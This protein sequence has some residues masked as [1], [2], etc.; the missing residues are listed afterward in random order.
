MCS[1]NQRDSFTFVLSEVESHSIL[2]SF[3]FLLVPK[4]VLK[5]TR[6]LRPPVIRVSFHVPCWLLALVLSYNHVS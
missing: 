4:F 6:K 1:G 3:E 2:N 5:G